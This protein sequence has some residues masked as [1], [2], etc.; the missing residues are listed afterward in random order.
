M[1]AAESIQPDLD[2]VQR[3]IDALRANGPWAH[4]IVDLAKGKLY[5]DV[6]DAPL[7][8]AARSRKLAGL[9]H[10]FDGTIF[11]GPTYR[12]SSRHPF[13]SAPLARLSAIFPIT[14]LTASEEI[15]WSQARVPS[16]RGTMRFHFDEPPQGKC[17]ATISVLALPWDGATGHVTLQAHGSTISIPITNPV[18]RSIDLIFTPTAGGPADVTMTIEA[19][20]QIFA[21]FF[22]TLGPAPLI[23]TQG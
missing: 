20:V 13:Q 16:G 1:S 23:A 4:D 21:F 17:M 12:L 3:H 22:M 6:L 9:G 14:Y 19:G 11:G 5:S 7:T 18:N 15:A 2:A 10:L 8:E